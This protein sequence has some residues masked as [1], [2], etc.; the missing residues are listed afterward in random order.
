MENLVGKRA[1]I[2]RSTGGNRGAKGVILDIRNNEAQIKFDLGV[3]VADGSEE[4][5]ARVD[6]DRLMIR[7]K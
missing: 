1:I 7:F 3:K 4:K 2:I 6:L 5:V